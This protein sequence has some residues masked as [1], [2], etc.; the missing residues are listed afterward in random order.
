M[1]IFD[2]IKKYSDFFGNKT[3]HPL[4]NYVDFSKSKPVPRTLARKGFYVIFIK[5]TICGEFRYGKK[6]YDYSEGS[7]FFTGPNQIVGSEPEGEIY[8]PD[9]KAI[10]F[11]AD[12]LNG[13]LLGKQIHEY[14]FFSYELN[15]SLHLSDRERE[16]V[17]GCF[18]NII[19]EIG[20][21][22]DKHSKKLI[23]A[24]LELLLKYCLRFYDRQFITRENANH[25]ILEQFER[26]LNEYILNEDLKMNGLPSVAYFANELSLSPNY[27][28]DLVKKETGNSPQD[29]IHLKLMELAKERVLDTTKSISEVSYEL[30]FRYPQ[31]FTRLFK[32]KVGLTPN[33]FRLN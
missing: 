25:G 6:H 18:A 17:E 16:I 23:V 4:I 11:H 29:F 30:G 22:I 27:F 1:I 14:S 8:Q 12:L 21:N 2:T 10:I 31:H 13:T 32:Q 3:L 9:G 24:N 15:E 7:M 20:Q 26:K 19:S 33:E 5:E 28:G